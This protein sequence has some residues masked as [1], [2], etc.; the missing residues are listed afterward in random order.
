[1]RV[2][3]GAPPRGA[4]GAWRRPPPEQQ[5]LLLLLATRTGRGLGGPRLAVAPREG[6]PAA[7]A[8]GDGGSGIPPPP[9]GNPLA[10]SPPGRCSV[11][12]ARAVSPVF[13]RGGSNQRGGRGG[14][15]VWGRGG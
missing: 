11:G 13:E 8:L 14:V 1:M 3:H 6:L 15:G 4:E 12:F 9:T 7:A 2:A 5:R 10:P